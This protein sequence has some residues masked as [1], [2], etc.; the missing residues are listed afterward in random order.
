M[1]V[2]SVS[3]GLLPFYGP[4]S[5]NGS[6][7]TQTASGAKAFP[8]KRSGDADA[9]QATGADV[10]GVTEEVSRGSGSAGQFQ[11]PLEQTLRQ[12]AT[13]AANATSGTSEPLKGAPSPGIAIYQRVSQYGN[14]EP[15]TSAL[16]RRWNSIMQSGKDADRAAA[17]FARLLSQN[18]APGLE[19]GILDLT[20]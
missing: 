1:S 19:S 16:L 5:G 15:S 4:V 9:S 13:I 8:E 2:N 12:N 11:S 20:A 18:E 6:Q 7:S 3:T 17:D 10:D 14:N